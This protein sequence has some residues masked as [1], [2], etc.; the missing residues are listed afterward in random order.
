VIEV[1]GIRED[2]RLIPSTSVGNNKTWLDV[3]DKVILEVNHAQDLR[4]EGMHDIYYGTAIPP[5]R[6]PIPMCAPHDRIGQ[7]YLRCD[8]GKIIGIVETNAPDRHTDFRHPTPPRAPSPAT[9]WISS[10]MR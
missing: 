7:K 1:A 3:A 4:L 9:C 2:G 6:K 8:P 5:Q 10:P